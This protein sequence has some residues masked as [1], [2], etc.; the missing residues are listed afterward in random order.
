MA[1]FKPFHM[2]QPMPQAHIQIPLAY[3]L[4]NQ[5]LGKV[6]LFLTSFSPKNNGLYLIDVLLQSKPFSKG[7]FAKLAIPPKGREPGWEKGEREAPGEEGGL[8]ARVPR[9]LLT[10]RRALLS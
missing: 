7:S 10:A 5:I 4:K 8:P 6:I 1:H 3:A 9:S 2:F